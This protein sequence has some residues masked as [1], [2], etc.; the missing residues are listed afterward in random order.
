MLR[1]IAWISWKLCVFE[2]NHTC[3]ASKFE[4]LTV[5]C[6]KI[7]Y[8]PDVCRHDASCANAAAILC[9]VITYINA[10]VIQIQTSHIITSVANFGPFVSR[11]TI[12]SSWNYIH[13]LYP[14]LF[15]CVTCSSK[16]KHHFK[17]VSP[18]HKT[19]A[20]FSVF[21]L[22][23]KTRF[24]LRNVWLSIATQSQWWLVMWW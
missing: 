21:S 15:L 11:Y 8:T 23:I 12:R 24:S 16:W 17:Y 13:T 5:A 14:T 6:I 10:V 7:F 1:A 4:T 22:L 19:F 20:Y 3:V 18:L 2:H 9:T